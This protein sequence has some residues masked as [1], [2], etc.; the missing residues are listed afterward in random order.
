[1]VRSLPR[2]FGFLTDAI[3]SVND[4]RF[5]RAQQQLQSKLLVGAA[6]LLCVA[7]PFD[8]PVAVPNTPQ[9]LTHSRNFRARAI[10]PLRMISFAT[11]KI[12]QRQMRNV[13]VLNVPDGSLR[14]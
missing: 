11:I 13:N 5:L 10:R 4:R 9:V 12:A 8:R 1:M 7:F 3:F 14:G 2:P 6:Q